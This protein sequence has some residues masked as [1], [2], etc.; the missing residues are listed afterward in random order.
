MKNVFTRDRN[1][2]EELQ[3]QKSIVNCK[4]YV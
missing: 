2:Q 3:R 1:E 4:W